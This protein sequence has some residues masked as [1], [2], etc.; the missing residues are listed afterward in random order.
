MTTDTAANQSGNAGIFSGEAAATTAAPAAAATT[1]A[2]A[3]TAPATVAAP[4]PIAPVAPE[5]AAKETVSPDSAESQLANKSDED[6]SKAEL[7]HLKK[8]ANL[9]GLTFS[10][11]I[12]VDAL[13]AKIQEKLAGDTKAAEATAP[14]AQSEINP[15]GD[16][17]VQESNDSGEPADAP[18]VVAQPMNARQQMLAEQMRLVRCHIVNLDP[19]KKD[20]PGE[21][22]SVANELLGNVR[23]FIPFGESTENGYH[24]PY[25]IYKMLERRKFLQIR[26]RRDPRTG[27]NVTTQAWVKEFSIRILEPL[28]KEQLRDLAQAQI[29]AGSID[30]NN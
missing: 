26:T 4:A 12:G 19:K 25:V 3:A 14:A 20:L 5:P 18:E 27:T 23:K 16:S 8:K 30:G 11:N 9:I 29:A 10:N 22:I 24:I 21:I 17:P 15:L 13:R 7:E 2:T 1:S 6:R 28:T